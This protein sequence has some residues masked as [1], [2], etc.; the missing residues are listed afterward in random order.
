MALS[1]AI[2]SISPMAIRPVAVG[3]QRGAHWGSLLGQVAF[4]WPSLRAIVATHVLVGQTCKTRIDSSVLGYRGRGRCCVGRCSRLLFAIPLLLHQNC[5]LYT[6]DAA[7][8]EDSV[9]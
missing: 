6:S 8:E 1:F 5:L 3:Q 9:D 2:S 7:D 4:P